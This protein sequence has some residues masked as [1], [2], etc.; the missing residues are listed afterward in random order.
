[1]KRHRAQPSGR[2][3]GQVDGRRAGEAHAAALPVQL[4]NLRQEGA[5]LRQRGRTGLHADQRVADR[6]IPVHADGLSVQESALPPFRR[7]H[8]IGEG[9]VDDAQQKLAVLRVRARDRAQPHVI[10]QVRRA[11]D[12]IDDEQLS[13]QGIRAGVLLAEHMAAGRQAHQRVHQEA[14]DRQVRVGDKIAL[15]LDV[16]LGAERFGSGQLARLADQCFKR[17]DH[18]APHTVS[19]TEKPSARICSR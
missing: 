10:H 12:G 6:V 7:E 15:A 19:T 16:H 9:V 1:M 5:L 2:H 17:F 4:E 11:V 14:A 13:L 3:I 18:A 8:L